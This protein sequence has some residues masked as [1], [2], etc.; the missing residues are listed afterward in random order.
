MHYPMTE[1]PNVNLKLLELRGIQNIFMINAAA[2]RPHYP[3]LS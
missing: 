1:A 2:Y 3:L